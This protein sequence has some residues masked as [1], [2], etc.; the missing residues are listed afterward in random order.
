MDETR[1]KSKGAYVPPPI[2]SDRTAE[3]AMNRSF[4]GSPRK[5]LHRGNTTDRPSVAASNLAFGLCALVFVLWTL[6]FGIRS[7][8]A[9]GLPKS[10]HQARRSKTKAQRSKTN[11]RLFPE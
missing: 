11:S 8:Y 10:K 7:V 6:D 5:E 9:L 2:E 4:M 1:L 3:I